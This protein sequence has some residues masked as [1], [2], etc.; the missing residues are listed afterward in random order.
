MDAIK[1]TSV[2]LNQR[3]LAEQDKPSEVDEALIA[4]VTERLAAPQ[5][6][7]VSLDEISAPFPN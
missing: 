5:R 4:V 2:D 1:P 7:K 3:S 6:V